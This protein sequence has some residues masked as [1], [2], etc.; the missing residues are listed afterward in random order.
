MV[1]TNKRSGVWSCC[2]EDLEQQLHVR[3]GPSR[4]PCAHKRT[5]NKPP[6]SVQTGVLAAERVLV[7]EET[8]W[9]SLVLMEPRWS[10]VKT[11]RGNGVDPAHPGAGWGGGGAR[12]W[13]CGVWRDGSDGCVFSGERSMGREEEEETRFSVP[14]GV[15][16]GGGGPDVTKRY[17]TAPTPS[18]PRPSPRHPS[19]PDTHGVKAVPLY[20]HKTS[21]SSPVK[22]SVREGVLPL[23]LAEPRPGSTVTLAQLVW[24]GCVHHRLN[25]KTTASLG[26]VIRP[27]GGLVVVVRGRRR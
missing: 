15:S 13:M 3:S 8:D 6:P 4:R 14:G 26:R 17:Q 5:E 27:P 11:S 7:L 19:S 10:T 18:S 2:L 1:G 22:V 12:F 23:V 24:G 16:R 25:T 20:R 21:T 9:A